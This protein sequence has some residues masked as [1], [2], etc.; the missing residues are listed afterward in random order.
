MNI[1]K[2]GLWSVYIMIYTLFLSLGFIIG[3]MTATH[4][5]VS[6]AIATMSVM[7]IHVNAN[8]ESNF[9]LNQTQL[10]EDMYRLRGGENGLETNK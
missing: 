5:I 1:K 4:Y 2:I 10:V 7:D 3:F 8:I 6:T 9:T